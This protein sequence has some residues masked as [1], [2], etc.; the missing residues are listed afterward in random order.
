MLNN[1]KANLYFLYKESVSTIIIFWSI[2]LASLLMF[3]TIAVVLDGNVAFYLSTT[4]PV[5]IFTIIFGAMYVKETFPFAIKLGTTRANFIISVIIYSLIF[6][7]VMAILN[8]LLVNL[9]D[10]LIERFS[11][12][13]EVVVT[14]FDPSF[15][16]QFG[17][18]Q[19]FVFG[20][21]IL[22][23]LF[24]TSLLFSMILYR[25]GYIGGGITAV[26]LL[27]FIFINQLRE[28]AQIGRA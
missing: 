25:F 6:T 10:F 24:V 5:G 11:M 2:F 21:F 9:F 20:Y 4:I 16:E 15:I 22:L 23:T 3:F 7:F 27:A 1:I 18:W 8:L 14:Q 12:G 19:T 26:V 17:I 13:E 28:F